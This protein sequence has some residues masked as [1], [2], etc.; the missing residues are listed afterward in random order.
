MRRRTSD[1]ATAELKPQPTLCHGLVEAIAASLRTRA[2]ARGVEIVVAH[3]AEDVVARTD[4]R[5]LGTILMSLIGGAIDCAPLGKV[6]VRVS[7][8]SEAGARSVEI[9]ISEIAAPGAAPAAQRRRG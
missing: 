9:S 1:M 3:I 5:T 2:A 4:R 6:H 7:R 8:S